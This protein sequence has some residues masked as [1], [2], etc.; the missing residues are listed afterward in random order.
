MP[1]IAPGMVGRG[2]NQYYET[3]EEYVFA[4][5]EALRSEWAHGRDSLVREGI[6]GARRFAAGKG[7]HGDSRDI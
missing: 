7:R 2:Q 4:I 3:E 1:A 6:A 5:A